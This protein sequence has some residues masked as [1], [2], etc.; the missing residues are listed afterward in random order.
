I[1]AALI[2]KTHRVEWTP[3]ILGPPALD[4]GMPA[5]WSGLPAEAFGVPLRAIR[6]LLGSE[7]EVAHGIPGSRTDQH[8]APYAITEEFAAVYRLH[9]PLP[10]AVVVRS[11]AGIGETTHPLLHIQ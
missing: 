7:S 1:N 5:N 6:A 8:S 3:G 2:A 4:F 10:E 11:L 9:P